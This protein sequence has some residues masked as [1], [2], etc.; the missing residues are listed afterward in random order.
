M[1]PPEAMTPTTC[2]ACHGHTIRLVRAAAFGRSDLVR[3]HDC[4]T[5]FLVPQPSD[6]RLAEI[7][8]ADYYEPWSVENGRTVDVMK[9]Q[10]FKPLLDECRIESGTALLDLGCATG[11]FLAEAARRGAQTYGI[12]LNPVAISQ[13]QQRVPGARLHA[14]RSADQPFQGVDFAAV[15]MIDFLEH[16]RDPEAELAIVTERMRPGARLIIS[17]PR[18]D[19]VLRELMRRN[20]PQY[21]EEHLTYFSRRGITELLE[22]CGLSVEKISA[23]RKA[24][25]LAYAHGQMRAYPVPV[26]GSAVAATYRLLPML[27]HRPVRVRLGE[28]TVIAR[29]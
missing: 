14:G 15:V 28:M 11:A 20:W 9:Q 27:R 19:S 5:E 12:D 24:L 1:N 25:T 3:C 18:V 23:T 2:P 6:D 21:R 26:L 7:Y 29:A 16:V 13:A 4:R 22:R 8:G 10:T 17:T